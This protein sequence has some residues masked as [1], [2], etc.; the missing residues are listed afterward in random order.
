MRKKLSTAA[1]SVIALLTVAT[2]ANLVGLGRANP[3]MYHVWTTPPSG[4]SPLVISVSSPKNNT[5][6]NTNLITITLNVSTPETQNTSVS[7]LLDVHYKADWIRNEEP[8]YVQNQYSPQF[9]SF[10]EHSRLSW[11][12][13]GNHSIVITARGGGGYAEGDTAYYFDMESIA[14]I[15]FTVDTSPPEIS[16]L[17]LKNET[18]TTNSIPLDFTVNEHTSSMFYSL[19]NYANT[20]I[21][22]NTT[23]TGLMDGSHNL[24][25][26]ANDTAGNARTSDTVFFN[27]QAPPIISILSPNEK[28]YVTSNN[29]LTFSISEPV[30]WIRY[31]LDGKA[32]ETIAGN[33]TLSWLSSGLHNLIVYASD[34]AGNIGFSETIQFSITA[35]TAEWSAIT[36]TPIAFGSAVL[37]VY[38]K[39]NKRKVE[40]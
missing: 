40:P 27:I 15:N 2:F 6:Y 12:P 20:T 9:P 29:L 36:L 17:S 25:V 28:T 10:T 32:N 11:V 8:V 23:L 21:D 14:I 38:F 7:Y 1:F 5:A 35:I 24:T 30:S 34:E 18:Y 16:L 3:Y 31:S 13:D 33:T 37:L 4:A 19:D 39:K 26:F 22:G